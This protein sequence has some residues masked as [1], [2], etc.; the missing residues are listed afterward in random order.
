MPTHARIAPRTAAA[1]RARSW[2]G[3]AW[4]RAVE[5]A[6]YGEDDLRR[7][8]ALARAGKVGGIAVE[9]GGSTVRL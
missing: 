2:W 5:E 8:R 1:A 6:A 3:K 4:L 7:G 9:P